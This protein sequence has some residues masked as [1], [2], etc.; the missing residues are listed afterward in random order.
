MFASVKFKHE[1][2]TMFR[3]YDENFIPNYSLAIQTRF[4][5]YERLEG[6]D[7]DTPTTKLYFN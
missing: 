4:R 7:E 2:E 6:M 5:P 3:E 1:D